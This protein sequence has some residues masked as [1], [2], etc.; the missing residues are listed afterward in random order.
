MSIN[1]DLEM[2]DI[3]IV[4][5]KPANLRL[6]SQMLR[7]EG[8]EV[9]AVTSGLRALNSIQLQ[10]PSLILLDIKMAEMDGYQVCERLKSNSITQDIPVI[11]ISALDDIQ[12][13]LEA[14]RVGGVDYITKPFQVDEVLARTRTHLHLKKLQ[15]QL[16]DANKKF[17]RELR[18]AGN[19]QTNFLPKELPRI[20]GW[21]FSAKL[22]PASETSGDFYDI[23]QLPNGLLGIVI[24][25]VVDK[26]VAA[27]LFMVLCWSLVRTYASMYPGQP[28]RVIQEV[29]HR[30]LEDTAGG[31]FVTIFFAVLDTQS[32]RMV[33]CN[34][35]HYPPLL[36]DKGA[37]KGYNQLK[38]TGS[39]LGVFEDNPLSLG[40]VVISHGGVLALYTDGIPDAQNA[41]GDFYDR[42]RLRNSIRNTVRRLQREFVMA[43]FLM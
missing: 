13:K 27:A 25:D 28:D 4:D 2:E 16:L 29:N 37:Q 19:V 36:F 14:F 6:L 41:R 42:V 39:A 21:Q 3:L 8:Y 22:L 24:A 38:S 7:D 30:I 35:G 31:Q 15:K 32:G 5:D 18:L 11:F 20:N 1:G 10:K 43:S 12:D 40:E 33:Y 17:E 26:G 34:A 9:R 23:L